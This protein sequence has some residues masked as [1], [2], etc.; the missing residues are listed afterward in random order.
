MAA[1]PYSI[2]QGDTVQLHAEGP[3]MRVVK[4]YSLQPYAECCYLD[5]QE[6][7]P[8]ML[9]PLSDLRVVPASDNAS[10]LLAP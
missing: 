8:L 6:Q 10:P 7:N 4:V 3:L 2:K 5:A 9:V 1:P